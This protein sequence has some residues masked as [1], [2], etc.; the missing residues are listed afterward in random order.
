MPL[1]KFAS[2]NQ[3]HYPDLSSDVSSVWNF[4]AVS[5]MSFPGETS[6]GVAKCR[7]FSQATAVSQTLLIKTTR[8]PKKVTLLTGCS[9]NVR[10]F[11]SQGQSKL[12]VIMRFTYYYLKQGL[13]VVIISPYS[14]IAY[15]CLP[16]SF[17]FCQ[18]NQRNCA[19][20]FF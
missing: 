18:L 3:K 6:G 20:Y 10:A 15:I 14:V 1:G 11:F 13:T 17:Q 5:Q 8:R 7:L 9:S 19:L 2:T 4:C 16:F 12:S